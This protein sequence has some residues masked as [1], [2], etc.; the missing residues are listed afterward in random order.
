MTIEV[1]QIL[2]CLRGLQRNTLHGMEWRTLHLSAAVPYAPQRLKYEY[3]MFSR[4]IS[5]EILRYEEVSMGRLKFKFKF[6]WLP[7]ASVIR[8][9]D[10]G[11]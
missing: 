1:P 5:P 9:I 6:A 11:L 10:A 2:K 4:L 8:G 7:V 3:Q